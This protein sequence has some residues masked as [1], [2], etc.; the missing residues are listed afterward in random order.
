MPSL[1]SGA[2][3]C[4]QPHSVSGL[5]ITLVDPVGI[6]L[7]PDLRLRVTASS[8]SRSPADPAERRS[9]SARSGERP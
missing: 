5:R 7:K 8:C 1:E 2:V 6:L 9:N 4:E 3:W